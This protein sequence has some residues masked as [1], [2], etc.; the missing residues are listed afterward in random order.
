MQANLKIVGQGFSLFQFPQ[1]TCIS[2]STTSSFLWW[3]VFP[4]LLLFAVFPQQKLRLP[5]EWNGVSNLCV[6]A[7][8]SFLSFIPMILQVSGLQPH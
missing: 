8:K 6:H 3:P 4:Q 5:Y 1:E 7:H 2:A